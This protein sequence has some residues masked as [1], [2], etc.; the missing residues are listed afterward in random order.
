MSQGTPLDAKH[1]R[2]LELLAQ[3]A[4]TRTLAR[5]MGFSEGTIRVYLHNLYRVLGVR[6]RTEA[7]LWHLARPASPPA[8]RA[9]RGPAEPVSFGEVALRD[10]LLATLGIMESFLGP[11]GRT[12]EAAHRLKGAH[13]DAELDSRRRLARLFWRALLDGDFHAAKAFHDEQPAG[14]LAWVAPSEVALLVVLLLVGGYTHA[15]AQTGSLIPRGRKGGAGLSVRETTLLQSL[16][17]ALYRG[18]EGLAALQKLAASSSTP[19]PLRHVAIASVFHV[20][21]M[22]GDADAAV[23]AADALWQE[24]ERSRRELEA[25]GVRPLAS[26]AASP[27]PDED[28]GRNTATAREK[29]LSPR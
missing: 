27:V 5:A 4:S 28:R 21:R 14:R 16:H 19:G 2:M 23:R 1:G 20:Q 13:A 17:D 3:G 25:M 6:N 24:A 26:R 11:Y 8:G 15:A 10:G 7:V 12:W 22:R 9:A 18:G 29:V